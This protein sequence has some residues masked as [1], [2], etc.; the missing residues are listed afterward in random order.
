MIKGCTKRV[1]VVK[2]VQSDMFEEAYFILKP[3]T[4][5]RKA[6]SSQSAFLTEA[7]RLVSQN[8][9]LSGVFVQ[10]SARI[11]ERSIIRDI[12]FFMSGVAVAGSAFGNF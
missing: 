5:K 1:V 9:D 8:C 11:K 6:S 3:Q 7:N 12:L 10:P 2:D 4:G